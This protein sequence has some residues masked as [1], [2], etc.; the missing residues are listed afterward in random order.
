VA[1]EYLLLPVPLPGPDFRR[2]PGSEPVFV[3]CGRLEAEKGVELLLR[4]FAGVRA[5][6]PE[7]R[8]R[9]VGKGSQRSMLDALV[10]QL[11]LG[12]AVTFRGW[13]APGDV[14]RE[15]VDAWALVA[16]SL[17]AEPLG[18]A[19]L[20]AVVR[21]VPV[22]ASADGGFG[23][24]VEDGVSGLLFPNGDEAALA[25]RLDA[26]ARRR[27]FPD[28]RLPEDVVRRARESTDVG[29]HVESLRR[30]FAQAA[31]GARVGA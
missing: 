13:L 12:G 24:T 25:D 16:P 4:A 30:I 1:A 22:V 6:V 23:E 9:I 19:A 29:R 3:Y 20:E 28:Q 11:G 18:L 17:W 26:V 31:G 14:E 8:L 27:A 7:A 21:G 10:G 15:L 2:A 5:R